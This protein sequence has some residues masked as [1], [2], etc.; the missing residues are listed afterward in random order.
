MKA[1]LL[2]VPLLALLACSLPG[3]QTSTKDNSSGLS[4]KDAQDFVYLGPGRPVL[5]RLHIQ[6]EGRSL[7]SVWLNCMKRI[8]RYLDTDRDGSISKA[9]GSRMPPAQLLFNSFYF[10]D[11]GP[12][13]QGM[14]PGKDGKV[15][16]REL[17]E[18]F[19]KSGG[20]PFQ[21]SYGINSNVFTE[22]FGGRSNAG[23]SADSINQAIFGL[24][25]TN[26][27]GKLS[28]DELAKAA[29]ILLTQDTDEDELLTTQE[30]LANLSPQERAAL[31][32]DKEDAGPNSK[33]AFLAINPDDAGKD[34]ARALQSRYSKRGL[35]HIQRK[36]I[37]LDE[38]TFNELDRDRDGF[39]DESELARFADRPADVEVII[40]LRLQDRK[41][42][43]YGFDAATPAEP[44]T[45]SDDPPTKK[46]PVP[47]K[48]GEGKSSDAKPPADVKKEVELKDKPAP[49]TSQPIPTKSD[50][51]ED[52]TPREPILE[53]VVRK[54]RPSPLA[55]KIR[56]S[57]MKDGIKQGRDAMYLDLGTVS[58]ELGVDSGNR[59]GM[60]GGEGGVP[61][62]VYIQQLQQAD[63]DNN[64]YLDAAEAKSNP[65]FMNLFKLMDLDGDGMLYEKELVGYLDRMQELQVAAGSSCAS[66]TVTD[67]GRGIFDLIDINKNGKLT[68]RELRGMVEALKTLD[69]N[70]D[71][72]ISPDEL[73]RKYQLQVRHGPNLMGFEGVAFFD[74]S[75]SNSPIKNGNTAPGPLWFRK[76]DK[77]SDGD[78]S[79][80]EFLGTDTDFRRIDADND[81]LISAEEAIRFDDERRTGKVNKK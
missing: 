34:L 16:L 10:G 45:K 39:L 31:V 69:T 19:R 50:G 11:I 78:V 18:Q 75:M 35:K 76:M 48:S 77:N 7:Q 28:R 49:A 56:G 40:R 68:I 33:A 26:K 62:Q 20:P 71:G 14:T 41:N 12:Q 29:D 6:V 2:C 4:A 81:A 5:Y 61:K 74:E 46:E 64:G 58:I 60:F 44:E 21:M 38:Q 8:F 37:G 42:G 25:D 72:F 80:R 70:K 13:Q 15:T 36:Q 1:S 51:K 66:M 9:E 27:D 55:D 47:E 67:V 57:D 24:L 30:L 54:G 32:V 52:K 65:L 17:A 22:S 3:A 53:L 79:R 43:P 23:V 59:F 63:K 73:P